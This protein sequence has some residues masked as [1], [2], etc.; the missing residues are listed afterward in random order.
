[1]SSLVKSNSPLLASGQTSQEVVHNRALIML[2]ALASSIV[3]SSITASNSPPGSPADEGTYLVGSAATG[4][5]SGHNNQIATYKSGWYFFPRAEGLLAYALNDDTLY[6]FDGSSWL[7][8]G[9]GD[10]S[11][12]IKMFAGSSAPA[13]WL[14]CDGSSVLRA[15]YAALFAVIG[16]TFGSVDGTHFTLPDFRG[17]APIGVGTGAGLTARALAASGGEE[18]HQLSVAELPAH[19]HHYSDDTG[20]PLV[21]D[22]GSADTLYGTSAADNTTGDTGSDTPHNNMQP[23]LAVNF[24][25][26]T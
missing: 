7:A 22:T 19:N 17:R 16:T 14:V 5:W 4:D 15:T 6:K 21:V 9:G 20:S 2:N 12:T 10:P 13:G 24:I 8:V 23:Y 18:T 3:V 11:G 25:I 26:K 1:M